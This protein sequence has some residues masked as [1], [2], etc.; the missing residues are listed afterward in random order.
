MNKE[1]VVLKRFYDEK[2][3]KNKTVA[4]AFVILMLISLSVPTVTIAVWFIGLPTS[5]ALTF[6]KKDYIG[7]SNE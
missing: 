6:A 1:E 2:L 7:G 3:L 5:L 4:L